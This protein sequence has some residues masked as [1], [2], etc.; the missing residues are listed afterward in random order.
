M[1]SQQ[2]FLAEGTISA[3][4]EKQVTTLCGSFE[5]E[6]NVA[7]AS[8]DEAGAGGRDLLPQG[9]PTESCGHAMTHRAP[10]NL[11]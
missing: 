7:E 3:E 2:N 4:E 8:D 11:Q 6:S 5:T 10:Q 9:Y 1:S